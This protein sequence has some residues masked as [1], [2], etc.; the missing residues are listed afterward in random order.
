MIHN[1][2]NYTYYY[3]TELAEN[4]VHYC[5]FYQKNVLKCLFIWLT[6]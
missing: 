1:Y 6:L 4:D 5:L 3:S 2:F